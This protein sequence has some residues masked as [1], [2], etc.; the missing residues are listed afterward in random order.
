MKLFLAIAVAGL[1]VT[2]LLTSVKLAE[3]IKE[4]SLHALL[5]PPIKFHQAKVI[6]KGTA[7]QVEIHIP[8]RGAASLTFTLI[9]PDNAASVTVSSRGSGTVQDGG[10]VSVE[11]VYDKPPRKLWRIQSENNPQDLHE[12]STEPVDNLVDQR[13]LVMAGPT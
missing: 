5:E 12:T 9:E 7:S 11:G 6:V 13:T 1:A 4:T 10:T 2:A 8:R 3:A